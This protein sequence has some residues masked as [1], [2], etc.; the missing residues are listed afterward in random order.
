[1]RQAEVDSGAAEGLTSEERVELRL[2]KENGLMREE[3]EIPKKAAAFFARQDRSVVMSDLRPHR[4]PQGQ[5]LQR[6]L[7]S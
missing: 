5:S 7:V 2:R 6:R 1:M 3:R 4:M